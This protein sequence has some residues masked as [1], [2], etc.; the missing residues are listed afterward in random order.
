MH[1]LSLPSLSQVYICS[2]HTVKE[3]GRLPKGTMRQVISDLNELG[4]VVGRDRLNYL[5]NKRMNDALVVHEEAVAAQAPVPGE[6]LFLP[7]TEASVGWYH[8]N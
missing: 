3:N 6:V 2:D 8:Y 4:I 5:R 7:Q 1:H